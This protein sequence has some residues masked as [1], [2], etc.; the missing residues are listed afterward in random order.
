MWPQITRL[1]GAKI[2]FVS[3][4]VWWGMG[5]FYK[6]FDIFNKVLRVPIDKI[7]FSLPCNTPSLLDWKLEAQDTCRRDIS[8]LVLL[9]AVVSANYWHCS[10]TL[11]TKQHL[12]PSKNTNTKDPSQYHRNGRGVKKYKTHV[13]SYTNQSSVILTNTS[14]VKLIYYWSTEM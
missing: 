5:H 2:R 1:Q 13:M 8:F 3:P 6:W 4:R 9:S 7:C 11:E 12:F 10:T 14:P